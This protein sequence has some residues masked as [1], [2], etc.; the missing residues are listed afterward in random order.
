M[1]YNLNWDI[2]TEAV[3]YSLVVDGS[4]K[5]MHHI[6]YTAL[7]KYPVDNSSSIVAVAYTL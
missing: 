4:R 7:N 5:I 1:L 2:F 6:L 3:N